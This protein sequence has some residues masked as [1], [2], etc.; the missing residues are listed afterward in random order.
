MQRHKTTIVYMTSNAIFEVPTTQTPSSSLPSFTN[1]RPSGLLKI[2]QIGLVNSFYAC[3]LLSS[4]HAWHIHNQN[5]C[6]VASHCDRSFAATPSALSST[7]KAHHCYC[8]E[9]ARSPRCFSN[10]PL[11]FHLRGLR[12][13]EPLCV[14]GAL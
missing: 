1:L 2:Q 11:L 6:L 8:R 5:A 12:L 14:S 4:I 10:S 13:I 3:R 9:C 7:S